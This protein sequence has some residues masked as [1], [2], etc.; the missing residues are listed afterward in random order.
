M[1]LPSKP[2]AAFD[3]EASPVDSGQSTAKRKRGQGPKVDRN[4]GIEMVSHLDFVP[5]GK[6]PLKTFFNSK[7]PGNDMEQVLVLSYYLQHTM[8]L[9]E[10]GPGHVLTAFRHV[11]KPVPADLKGT[12]RNMKKTKAWL[13]FGDI[14][15]IRMST[16]GDNFVEHELPKAS[17]SSE[18]GAT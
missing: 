13:T 12:I 14:E 7:S 3:D 2:A 16:V 9:N 18:N 8:G 1:D 15:R 10:F 4:A 11:L 6:A 5:E 17:T